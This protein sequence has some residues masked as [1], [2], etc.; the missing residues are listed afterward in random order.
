MT[1]SL[2][3]D[4]KLVNNSS[5]VKIVL[6]IY[7]ILG[8]QTGFAGDKR[9]DG[10]AGTDTLTISSKKMANFT[11]I[12]YDGGDDPGGTFI[13]TDV[14]G[15]KIYAKSIEALTVGGV[16]WLIIYGNDSAGNVIG[17]G[18][19]DLGIGGKNA[20]A[21][22]SGAENKFVLFDNGTSVWS[23]VN[24]LT[25]IGSFLGN[26]TPR[27][28]TV[29]GS[30]AN[31]LM[32]VQSCSNVSRA[33]MG[34]GNDKV[35]MTN[36]Q[37]QNGC[38]VASADTLYLDA[39]DDLV[40]V[41]AADLAIDSVIDGGAGSDY[42]SFSYASW[43]AHNGSSSATTYTINAGVTTN[44][45]NVMGSANNDILTGDSNANRIH[46]GGGNDTVNGGDGNDVLYGDV[47]ATGT[48][49][50]NSVDLGNG[51]TARDIGGGYDTG[52]DI[53]NGNAG[54][55]ILYGAGG[56][57][58]LDGGTGADTLTGG[59]GADTFVIRSGVGHGGSSISDADTIT[60]FTDGTDILGLDPSVN[61]SD[62][63]RS[64]SGSDT[65]ISTASK[66]LVRLAGISI[67]KIGIADFSSTSTSSQILDGSSDDDTSIGGSGN[68]TFNGGAGND[69]LY[70][71]NG[72]DI[73]N[74]TSKLG[75]F[76]ETIDGG[77]GTDVL[78][79]AYSK[80]AN[81]TSISY[82]GGDDPG[83]TFIFTDV[84]GGKIYAKSI[85]ALTV[86]GVPWL[87]IYGNDSAGNVIGAGGFDLGIG[88]KNAGA[89]YSGAEN[90]FVLFDNGT[91]VWSGV[92]T[93]T[94]I[95]SFLGNNTPRDLT[96][97]G[98]QANDLMLVQSC[99]NVSRAD[100]GDG[101]DKVSMTNSQSQNGCTVASADTLYLD[102]GDDLVIVDA[103]DLAIDSVIDGGAGSD[104]ISFSYASWAAHNGSSSATTYTINA[105]VTTN[106]ENV[107]GSANND[108]LTGDSNANRIHGGGGND[109]VN[110]G[111][112]NDVLY[113]DVTATG[114]GESN[115]VDLGNGT[116]A[117]DIGGGYDT[118]NDIVNG[119]AGN[120]ILYGAG[121]DDT[122]DGGTGAD[123]LT[124]GAGADT[125]VIRSGVGHGGS[126]IS[127]AD[128]ITDF[129]DGTDIL[130]LDPSVNY[131]DLNRSQSGSD[132]IIS[133][134]SKH[135]VRLAGISIS[136]IG[137]ADF[138]S[139]STSSQILDGS[140][141][142]DT[143]IGGSGNDTF[144][145]GAGN[146]TLYG[147]NGDDIFNITSKLGAF[148]ETIDG[149]SGT[150]VLN[151][152]YSKM[153]NFTS[154]SYDGGDDPGGTFIFTDVNGGKIYAKSI[155][156][157]TV[158]GVPWLIIYGNDSAGNV[159]GAGGFDLG[160]G[161]K[162][163]GALYSGAENKF[164]LFDNGTS[165][166]SGV[167]T[168]TPIGSFLG[169]N[170]PRDLTVVG[171][172]AN[173]L[174]LVQSC[175]N[176]S[177]ADMGDGNDKVSMTNS[178]S[179]N[180]CT[181]AS[182]DTLYLDAGDDLVIVDAADLAIDS[183]IDGGA[184]S[185]YISFSYASWAAHNGSSS[186]TT[187]TINA[188]V[189]T[190]FE[191]VMGSANND[192]LTGDSNANRIHGGGGND[193]V[194]GGDGNDVLY[195]DVTATGTG[196]SYS[197]D[198]G[199]GT[200]A[201]DIGGGYDTGNDIVNG[202]AGNDILYGAGGDDTLDGGTGA[203]TLTGGAGADTFVIRSG[204]GH[205][206]SSISDADTIT[207]FTDGTDYIGLIELNY[208]E[209]KREQ[210]TGSYSSHVVVKKKDTGEFLVIIQNVL[211]KNI[212]DYDFS[213]I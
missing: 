182:A 72:D 174:M 105:G 112:G 79:I 181:V 153:A 144:N 84:N 164:V 108:I 23:G 75:A 18:G 51:T 16:P 119:N 87:I 57:D 65:I 178:Q 44:F 36:S 26:N 7:L 141:D 167:N 99:S 96:V 106:F 130:G 127:D 197:V 148:I 150:D 53:V 125:F 121:G 186:A 146:D 161:G 55:D 71:H 104:Y 77:S 152:A 45:E 195:G 160:I 126:S 25:P 47:T 92:N 32:L 169:N 111:D 9:V 62:L 123:T 86:G 180:G 191:N 166:W 131:S 187:Y 73:F 165:V 1:L 37:S 115:S 93:L 199:N 29:V 142:D 80:M 143:S 95:G 8:Y 109:T 50:S 38:T 124:G 94:P 116:T 190:N 24:T 74:I 78:N 135:L 198:L 188:G 20:G 13:F 101:N 159:I 110:G 14:N 34:D 68:D 139:T 103:A 6:V 48:G 193:T 154:I 27:D 170:T 162:N 151:I 183:V 157:L 102:A 211:L 117:R 5:S 147:H 11:S 76:I 89:L 88:G 91:S 204:V 100:M 61:Y 120:D 134:A 30:Q 203:D 129:T 19:F 52:N 107:M 192:I 33:D 49:E 35:S 202:N 184:G 209:L 133:T 41:D 31:D 22:Y 163:A 172:Q 82:D 128:T 54:N 63:N 113:G 140:S 69:T 90:K 28:L 207:D 2:L 97:V 145:G 122:L 189:T 114:T 43:A 118:G 176:V 179:Q 201:R 156:A 171:S 168:L 206:G 59:A 21:L 56:D 46:G 205:G 10:G 39:G 12:S 158:G 137:I 173:D 64:Q 81:F 210:G 196:E 60:D 66:H 3:R 42:I 40:I 136:K 58:T 138:S 17:A 149:G 85:E 4:C 175:S 185:D 83:G 208:D 177:R 132:T 98:S 155:E 200:T 213:A 212:D 67:S 15:G 70:G 194:N